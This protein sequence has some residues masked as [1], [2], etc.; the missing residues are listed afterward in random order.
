MFRLKKISQMKIVKQKSYILPVKN[1][2]TISDMPKPKSLPIIGTKLEF[3]AAGGANKDTMQTW[4]LNLEKG[5]RFP[6][7]ESELYRLSSNVIIN[8]L[9]GTHSLELS[10]HYNEML[11]LFSDSMKKIF[12]T[13]TK[14]YS[15][16]V[17]WC[18]KLNLKVWRDFKESVDLTLFLG[19][20]ITRE[21]MFN[22]NKSDGLLKR[23]TEENM[24]PEIITRIVSDLIIAA[25]DTTTYTALWTLL[26]LT[27]NEDTLKESRKGD[28]KYIKYIVKESMRLYPVAPFLTRILPQ[29]TI[30]GDYKL[31]KGTPIIASIY[32]TGRDKQNFSEP[33]SFLPYRW[34]KTDPRKK[35]LI[36]HVPP[37]TLPFALGSRSC[38]GKKIA[39]KQLSEFI[40]QITYNFDLK[41]NN[42]QQIKSVTSQILIP[43]QNI[44]FSLSVRKQ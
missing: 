19:R 7:I 10:D 1:Y 36:N 41:C 28:Q 32:T 12:Q 11:S 26:L 27:R 25:G 5:C 16:P 17:N 24:S 38:I 4:K 39:M 42:N 8:I 2:L 35:D 33:N 18:Q 23:M 14:L 44:D 37:A 3:L 29:E 40:S 30:L 43:D 22:K 20:K 15:I 9:L 21:M 31:S 6:N 34:D 13:T